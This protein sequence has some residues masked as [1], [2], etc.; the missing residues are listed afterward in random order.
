MNE[1]KKYNSELMH[2]DFIVVFS[3]CDLLDNEL[4]VEFDKE[5]KK[6]FKGIPYCMISAI[7][8][9]GLTELKDLIWR[10]LNTTDG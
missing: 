9:F 4:K 1:L 8:K 5:I 6:K 2:K 10:I 7:D 3:K